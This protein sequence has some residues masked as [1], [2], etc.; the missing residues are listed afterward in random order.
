MTTPTLVNAAITAMV[1]ALTSA[2]A[3]CAHVERGRRRAVAQDVDLAIVVRPVQSEVT[4]SALA[5]GTPVTW[6]TSVAVEC[7][8]RSG[9]SVAADL[10]VDPLID[11]AY[12]RLLADPTLGGAV[13]VIK[14]QGIGYD[15]DS[16]GQ[17]TTC[18]TLVFHIVHRTP[19][20]T[21]G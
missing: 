19:G 13:V 1:A 9:A 6:L 5:Y 4:Q 12:A 11:S 8:A 15:F 21:L 20:N 7:Y 17:Q 3:V 16:D 10:A 14:P 2:P 18:A